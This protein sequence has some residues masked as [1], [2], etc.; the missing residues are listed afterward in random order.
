VKLK[1]Y[2]TALWLSIMLSP[3]VANTQ[4]TE[5]E[6]FELFAARKGDLVQLY[7]DCRAWSAE[8]SGFILMRSE[9]GQN[10]WEALHAAPLIPAIDP[11]VS[12]ENRGLNEVQMADL[13]RDYY[14]F[15]L[16]GYLSELSPLAMQ[17]VLAAQ[18]GPGSGDRIRM[19]RDFRVAL[20]LGFGF[21]DNT[22]KQATSYDYALYAF[23]VDGTTGK[24]PL[25]LY[26]LGEAP[27]PDIEVT[28]T[29]GKELIT[30]NWELPA[31][32]VRML[33]LLGYLVHR[34][35]RDSSGHTV[36]ASQPVGFFRTM[37]DTSFFRVNDHAADPMQ[38]YL[39]YLT[40]V[41]MFQTQGEPLEALYLSDRYKPV[42]PP[43]ITFVDLI[44]D[45]Y[46]EVT[47]ETHPDDEGLLK[48]FIIELSSD[49]GREVSHVRLDTIAGDQRSYTDRR[50]KQYGEIY[51]YHIRALG[52][53]GQDVRS[54]PE[55]FYYMG[56]PAPPEVTG[57]KGKLEQD[58][59][60]A[61]IWLEWDAKQPTDTITQGYAIYFDELTPDSLLHLSALPLI[62]ENQYRLP[63]TTR[64]GRPYRVQVAGISHQGRPGIPAEVTVEVGTL[65]LPRVLKVQSK[66]VTPYG[67][68]VWW[69]YPQFNDINGFRL[70][71]NGQE[72]AG[73]DIITGDM[74]SYLLSGNHLE[75]I[76]NPTIRLVAVGSVTT[77]EPGMAHRLYLPAHSSSELPAPASL[78]YELLH[79]SGGTAVQ[80]CWQPPYGA[81]E[82]VNGYA[83]FTDYA[84]RGHLQ[85][86]NN[87]PVLRETS[88][89][90]PLSQHTG[91]EGIT[92]GIAA[93]NS[94]GKTGTINQI[95][96]ALSD[97]DQEEEKI[98]QE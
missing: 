56:L 42:T 9:A 4:Q 93:I 29:T 98:K 31:T 92:I 86:M 61:F 30:L 6:D 69:E 47:W 34:T 33:S 14:D 97:I 48:H 26:R 78:T 50:P 70:L 64:G 67:L 75:G 16:E 20:L 90:Y 8:M 11:V 71:V 2:I 68:L 19:K 3:L 95:Y 60:E 38:D 51:F 46:M 66:R 80:L 55:A 79:S 23:N 27:T 58:N 59:N 76:D 77:S 32:E 53:Y 28:F 89:V 39:Y 36:V 7:W 49:P 87:V 83:L 96:I 18:N 45:Q 1:H 82:E 65:H 81:D 44:E 13:Q 37:N 35:A 57:L 22:A 43:K 54:A 10:R 73:T 62:G 84:M 52:Y 15:I 63:L 72:V 85:R 24:V 21:T 25:A 17:Q 5:S 94:E 12:L 88:F 40:P 91:K 74:R 41:N